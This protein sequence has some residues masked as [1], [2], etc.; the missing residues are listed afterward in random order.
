VA[1][2]NAT[3]TTIVWSVHAAGTTAEGAAIEGT[4][5][6]AAGE[7]TV[8][9]T[10]TI[11]GGAAEDTPYIQD[12][13]ITM[14]LSSSSFVA[15]T[16]ISNV[17]ADG[18]A[19][20]PL[21][22]TGPVAP[23]NAT[24]KTI[25]WSVQAEGTTAAGAAIT[26][27]NTLTAT[28]IGTVI[29]TATIAN[30]ATED[31]PYAQEFTITMNPPYKMIAI[32]GGTVTEAN[33]GSGNE[34]N[35]AAG[36]NTAGDTTPST[37]YTKPYTMAPFSMGETEVTYE[38]WRAV[39]LWATDDARGAGKYSFST[40]GVMGNQMGS[41]GS[42]PG[43]TPQ[44]PVTVMRWRD[45]VVWCNAYSEYLGKTPVYY[46]NG[47]A[48][49]TDTSKVVRVGPPYSGTGSVAVGNGPESAAWNPGANGFRLPTEAEWE[50]AARGGSPS[51]SA[52]W[53]NEFAGTNDPSALD[54][55]AW[56]NGGLTSTTHPVKQKQ[57]N[58]AGLYDMSG[59]VGEF[60]WD[61]VAGTGS[62]IMMGS[63]GG[64]F[65]SSA[66]DSKI[67]SRPI[68]SPGANSPRMAG[69]FLGFR[70]VSQP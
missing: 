41:S 8:I 44:H 13:T 67:A 51:T 21:T 37:N 69:Q 61:V 43:A 58:S 24:N 32:S 56:Y 48:D 22:L 63:R 52:P 55:Y 23:P 60:I 18:T 64:N 7:G 36:A 17:P 62:S 27:G 16:G 59:N 33:T 15:V 11:T 12:F 65:Y 50:Y 40:P 14:N 19:G 54:Q 29:V 25:A 26:A 34:T 66:D 57:P 70:V 5:L 9:V 39:Y 42:P 45:A 35:W 31:T 53:T 2:D 28:G 46:E 10:A 47:T 30:G 20:T 38:L 68:T 6:T 3:N 1:P 4:T 49:F